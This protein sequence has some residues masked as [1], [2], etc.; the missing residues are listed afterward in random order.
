MLGTGDM[1]FLA[2]APVMQ[3]CP[4]RFRD[5]DGAS[6]KFHSCRSSQIPIQYRV[7]TI[8]I[9]M[10][11]SDCLGY[12]SIARTTRSQE[13]PRSRAICNH[14]PTTPRQIARPGHYYA[15]NI[16]FPGFHPDGTP[17]NPSNSPPAPDGSDFVF[18][19]PSNVKTIGDALIEKNISWRYYGGG[20]NAAVAGAPN[21]YCRNC[22]PMQF[23]TSIMTNPAVRTEHNKDIVDFFADVAN[24]TLPA[25]SFVKPSE[26]VDGHPRDFQARPF[27]GLFTEHN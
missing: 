5:R 23:A 10:I 11:C 27:R 4:H 9:G 18:V 3:L 17:A 21:A 22:N 14:F 7:P 26:F 15:V 24:G 13:F 2:M 1:L 8:A 20:F 12:V 16:I 6:R 25:V 19:P